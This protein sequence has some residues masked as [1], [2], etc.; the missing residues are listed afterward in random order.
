MFPASFH[1]KKNIMPKTNIEFFFDVKGNPKIDL[2]EYFNEF[3]DLHPIIYGLLFPVINKFPSD[4]IAVKL[5]YAEKFADETRGNY[6]AKTLF[7]RI[8]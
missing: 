5:F 1:A 2:N 7:T 3:G 8:N 4:S 6:D